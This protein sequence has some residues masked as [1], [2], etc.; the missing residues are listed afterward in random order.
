MTDLLLNEDYDLA[1]VGGDLVIGESTQQHQ[2]LLL[3]L[4]PGELRQFPAVGVGVGE[5]LLDGVGYAGLNSAVKR[6]F[7]ADGMKVRTIAQAKNGTLKIDAF[8][9]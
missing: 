9:E 6:A 4:T 7:E 3:L 8:Y 5:Y 1:T 2:W